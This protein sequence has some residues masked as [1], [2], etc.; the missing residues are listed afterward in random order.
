MATVQGA[1]QH[2]EIVD[3]TTSTRSRVLMVVADPARSTTHRLADRLLGRLPSA[4]PRET[5]SASRSCA[6][7]SGDPPE[8]NRLEFVRR[9]GVLRHG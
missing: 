5:R 8:V 3:V 4:I 2:H 1:D 9:T 6:D 7:P